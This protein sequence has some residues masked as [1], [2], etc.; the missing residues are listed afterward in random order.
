MAIRKAKQMSLDEIK[1]NLAK[2]GVDQSSEK[3]VVRRVLK[4]VW[5]NYEDESMFINYLEM[6]KATDKKNNIAQALINQATGKLKSSLEYIEY[7]I[8]REV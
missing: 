1:V 4:T 8:N 5:A 3:E 7:L 6:I 2:L